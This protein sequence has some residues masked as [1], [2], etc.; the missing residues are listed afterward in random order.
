LGPNYNPYL[1]HLFTIQDAAGRNHVFE[2]D[3]YSRVISYQPPQATTPVYFYVLCTLMADGTTLTNCF[4]STRWDLHYP[5]DFTLYLEPPLLWDS[6][7]TV[8]RN[9]KVWNYNSGFTQ[10][11]MTPPDPTQLPSEWGHF[12]NS[13]LGVSWSAEGNSTPGTESKFGPTER[14][15]LYDGTV[16]Q[17][18]RSTRN[19][20]SSVQTNSGIFT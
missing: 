15:V 12:G 11:T 18:E 1:H 19:N 7:S 14:V 10:G 4:G 16:Y 5:S 13:P 3:S 17:Y 6:V 8:T 9:G 2:L 20:V